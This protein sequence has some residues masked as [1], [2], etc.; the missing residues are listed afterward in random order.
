MQ[1]KQLCFSVYSVLVVN[2]PQAT[3]AENSDPCYSYTVLNDTWRATSNM[4]Q[5]DLRCDRYLQWQ[6]WYRMFHLGVSVRMPEECVPMKRCSTHVPLWLTSPH[7]RPEDGIVT[8]AL[9]GHWSS[10]C[11]QYSPSPI[12]V[13]TCPGN[14]TVYKLVAPN[15]C[16][17]GYCAG[18]FPLLWDF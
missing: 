13:K 11:C 3:S 12:Q 8:R 17:L 10:N 14:Y 4:D 9:C 1:Y 18:K 16:W 15:A 2:R 5:S 7:P 6:G